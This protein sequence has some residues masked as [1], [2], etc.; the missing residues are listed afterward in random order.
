M[1]GREQR[2]CALGGLV[3]QNREP[4]HGNRVGTELRACVAERDAWSAR[5]TGE[6]QGLTR[7]MGPR[8]SRRSPGAVENSGDVVG[9]TDDGVDA[10]PA[11][12][13]AADGHVDGERWAEQV[14]SCH[15]PDVV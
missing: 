10:H 15:A 12:A 1:L 11:A 6:Q 8:W 14:G 2:A 13:L 7:R 3:A 4:E 9:V 5:S